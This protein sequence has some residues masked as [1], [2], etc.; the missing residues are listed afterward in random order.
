MPDL[1]NRSQYENA[2]AVAVSATHEQAYQQIEKAIRENPNAD[3]ITV[4]AALITLYQ[5]AMKEPLERAYLAAADGMSKTHDY[6]IQMGADAT[7]WATSYAAYLADLM[8][9]NRHTHLV[10]ALKKAKENDW[11]IETL[12]NY[13]ML[14]YSVTNAASIAVTEVTNA[15][16]EAEKRWNILWTGL[17]N[18]ELVATV[19]TALD[20]RVCEICQP[21]ENGD[22]LLVGFPPYHVRCRCYTMYS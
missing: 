2:L 1:V 10:N 11:S 8:V 14:Y 18:L 5:N 20:D 7:A 9:S 21:K 15:V 3:D 12:L 19:H 4:W 6:D 22:P 17:G 16:I 13:L